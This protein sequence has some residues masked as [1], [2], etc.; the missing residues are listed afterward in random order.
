M[1]HCGPEEKKRN[2][3][4][5]GRPPAEDSTRTESAST[6]PPRHAVVTARGKNRYPYTPHTPAAGCGGI[7]QGEVRQRY[8][9][10]GWPIHCTERASVMDT[11]PSN[12]EH[13]VQRIKQD[14][15]DSYDEELELEIDD[16]RVGDAGKRGER[17]SR[18]SADRE[19]SRPAGLFPGIAPS[20]RRAGQTPGLGA[21]HQAQGGDPVRGPRRCRQGRR[22]Q[23]DNAAPESS[24]SA[25]W[26][27]CPH[28]TIANGPSGT[29]SAMCRICPRA[30]RWS[31]SIAAGTTA[32]ESSG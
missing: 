18:G 9:S 7:L 29:S 23:A 25:G 20:A 12:Y 30:A 5:N 16:D 4:A 19:K 10:E 2:A 8:D 26:P 28:P 13:I 3:R 24:R 31:C 15:I 27:R 32:P 21:A 11:E 1:L 14:L 17:S 22:D 6:D